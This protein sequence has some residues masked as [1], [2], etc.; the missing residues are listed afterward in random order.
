M[1]RGHGMRVLFVAPVEEGSGEIVTTL[2]MARDLVAHGSEVLVLGS[3]LAA[4]LLAADLPDAVWPLGSDPEQSFV[5]WTQALASFRPDVVVFADLPFFWLGHGTVQLRDPEALRASIEGLSIPVLT[6]DHMGLAQRPITLFFGPPHLATRPH[7]IP[8]MPRNVGRLLP[9]PM[10]EPGPV[11]AREGVPFRFWDVPFVRPEGERE[12]L[13]RSLL[14]DPSELLVLFPIPAWAPRLAEAI[15]HPYYRVLPDFLDHYLG[16]L[17]RDVTVVVVNGSAIPEREGGRVRLLRKPTMPV[18]EFE[19]LLFAADMLLTDNG[20]SIAMGKALCGFQIC[21]RLRNRW[22]LAE[23]AERLDGRM[24]ELMWDL[25]RAKLGSVHPYEVFPSGVREEL[26]AMGLYRDNTITRAFSTLELYGGE[27]T[28]D[29]LHALL[30]DDARRAALRE[31]QA[32]YVRAL[33]ALPTA[34][35]VLRRAVVEG[36]P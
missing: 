18:D 11:A 31:Q 33:A 36:V 27:A 9:C 22:T 16:G 21:A 25:E 6:L 32:A 3:D 23:L 12:Q 20:I 29:E 28:R 19:A 1:S 13:R 14:R 34:H 26:E 2:H 17:P 4:R 8:A 35:D 5:R 30:L 7:R 24:R 10:H 15:G